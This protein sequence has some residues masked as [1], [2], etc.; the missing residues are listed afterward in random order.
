MLSKLCFFQLT[1]EI[2]GSSQFF[3]KII[4]HKAWC[5][6]SIKLAH[7]LEGNEWSCGGRNRLL[8]MLFCTGCLGSQAC[9]RESCCCHDVAGN[10][11]VTFK[12]HTWPWV[13]TH[14][15]FVHLSYAHSVGAIR[16]KESIFYAIQITWSITRAPE[17][18]E[19]HFLEEKPSWQPGYLF[20]PTIFLFLEQKWQS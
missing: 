1:V 10:H 13:Q 6:K 5:G 2:Q 20:L 9:G 15:V 14:L 17:R 16:R 19:S 11:Y 4:L 18:P 8:N 7:T 3:K 12:K